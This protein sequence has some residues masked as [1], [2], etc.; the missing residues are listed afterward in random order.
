MKINIFTCGNNHSVIGYGKNNL[1]ITNTPASILRRIVKSDCFEVVQSESDQLPMIRLKDEYKQ[2]VKVQSVSMIS[3]GEDH[4]SYSV[5]LCTRKNELLQ[6]YSKKMGKKFL[7]LSALLQALSNK[8]KGVHI[9]AKFGKTGIQLVVINDSL[10]LLG[11][12]IEGK[13][14]CYPFLMNEFEAEVDALVKQAETFKVV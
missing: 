12:T 5:S 13:K 3:G 1:L 6:F 14:L 4:I 10:S 7:S 9:G 8:Q 2:Y 11:K